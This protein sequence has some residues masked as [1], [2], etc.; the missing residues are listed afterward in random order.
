MFCQIRFPENGWIV[1]KY[2]LSREKIGNIY[3]LFGHQNVM[4]VK[5]AGKIRFFLDKMSLSHCP[6]IWYVIRGIM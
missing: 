3:G 6:K 4:V 5:N 2:A 1:Y